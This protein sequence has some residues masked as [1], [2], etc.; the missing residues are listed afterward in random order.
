MRLATV[1]LNRSTRATVLDAD[2]RHHLLPAPSVDALRPD[3]TIRFELDLTTDYLAKDQTP[4][5][6]AR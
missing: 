6:G 4:N 5:E 3:N 2:G 1:R